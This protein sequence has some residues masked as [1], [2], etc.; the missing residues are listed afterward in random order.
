MAAK[1]LLV[2]DEKGIRRVLGI[3]LADRGYKVFTAAGAEEALDI[4]RETEPPIVLT[5]IKMPGMDGIELLQKIKQEIPD[6]EVIMITGHGDMDLAIQSLKYEATDFITKPIKD[7]ALDIALKRAAEKIYL[8]TK[9]RE[10]SDNLERLVEEKTR[11]LL[12]AERLAAVGQTVAGVA[13]AI[14]NVAGGLT[15]GGFVLEKGIDLDNPRYISQGW[16]MLRKNV[17][18]IKNMALDLL[19]Y[20]REKEPEYQLC[21][22]NEPLREV[23]QLLLANAEE[24]GVDLDLQLDESLPSIWFDPEDIHRCLVNLA[25]NAIDAC[26]DLSCSTKS[27][28]VILRSLRREPWAVEYQVVDDGCGM[29]EEISGKIFQIFFTTKGS[30]GTGLG[31]MLTKK[32]IEEHKGTI[33][34]ETQKDKG[35][36]FVV[37][38]PKKE[39]LRKYQSG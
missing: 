38:L 12:E 35:T 17:D 18:R 15:G 9:L 39:P 16:E 28:R 27:C 3:A 20:A 6:T 26:T 19:N 7:E 31:L 24:K 34:F 21:D 4:F 5:D 11:Q 10:Y 37:Q 22:P 2:D 23:F 13:H 8:K 25:S 32:I 14:K 29:S 30:Q 36:K 33:T 1:V